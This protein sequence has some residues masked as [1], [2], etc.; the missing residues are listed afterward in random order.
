MTDDLTPRPAADTPG[1]RQVSAARRL[2]SWGLIGVVVVALG[3]IVVRGLGEATLFYLNA[4][5][6]VEQRAELGDRR[7]TLQ[8]AVVGDSVSTTDLGVSFRVA[9]NS[10]SVDVD[11]VGDPPELFQPDIPV[12]LEGRWS[13]DRFSSDRILIKHTEVYEEENPDRV[14]YLDDEKAGSAGTAASGS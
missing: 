11:H 9:F 6:A 4:D 12:V 8:G 1:G 5:E 10:V 3:V 7:F 14:N 13:G 2:R